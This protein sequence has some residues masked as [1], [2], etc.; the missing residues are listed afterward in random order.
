MK[1]RVFMI[2]GIGFFLSFSVLDSFAELYFEADFDFF[3]EHMQE[4]KKFHLGDAIYVI[5][6]SSFY[7]EET[8]EHF[9]APNSEFH[10]VIKNPENKIIHEDYHRSDDEGKM[11][12]SFDI[13]NDFPVGEYTVEMIVDKR[14]HLD[15]DFFVGHLP[16]DVVKIKEKFDLWM[17]ESEIIFPL[18]AHL[19]VVLC[20]DFLKESN[21]SESVYL[22]PYNEDILE[23]HS[24]EIKAFYTS[25]DGEEFV[26]SSNSEK[27]SCTSFVS[28]LPTHVPGEWS[29]YL[30]AL[31]VE[32]GILYEASS[33]SIT[34]LAKEPLFQGTVE[35]I[36]IPNPIKN[37]NIERYFFIVDELK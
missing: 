16:N 10:M 29:V 15:S 12:F 18:P 32:N 19:N 17:E 13:L 36:P 37:K 6:H 1:D 35:K 34:Y 25:P 23:G 30:K 33:H 31:W 21:D 27:K 20:S 26:T 3:N 5:G 8:N 28:R 24:V 7:K 4:D 9:P 11:E 2:I 22:D 14:R